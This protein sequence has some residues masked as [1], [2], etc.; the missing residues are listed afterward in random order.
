MQKIYV[1]Q[2]GGEL[3]LEMCVFMWER[4]QEMGGEEN[5]E[6]ELPE[7]KKRGRRSDTRVLEH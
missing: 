7:C 3:A 6:Y 1:Q 4:C 5:Y 2:R